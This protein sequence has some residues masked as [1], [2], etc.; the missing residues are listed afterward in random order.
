MPRTTSNPGEF[1]ELKFRISTGDKMNPLESRTLDSKFRFEVEIQFEAKL[2]SSNEAIQAIQ[3]DPF[4][5]DKALS[6]RPA[7]FIQSSNF[8]QSPQMA[9]LCSILHFR[10]I[11]I[12][13]IFRNLTKTFR[14]SGLLG[15][16]SSAP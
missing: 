9:H 10:S 4:R 11:K 14:R 2:F 3:L 15:D 1:K 6:K 5:V 12:I 13:L 8:K 7:N 16:G